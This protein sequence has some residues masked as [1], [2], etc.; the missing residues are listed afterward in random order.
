MHQYHFSLEHKSDAGFTPH[1]F[2]ILKTKVLG[3]YNNLRDFAKES[4]SR[5]QISGAGFTLLEALVVVAI[6][7]IISTFAI[8]SLDRSR[9]KARDAQ[10]VSDISAI[11]NAVELYIED[12]GSVPR[13]G[14]WADFT[15]MVAGYIKNGI[16]S[17][18]TSDDIPYG[19]CYDNDDENKYLVAAL[20]EITA[21]VEGDLDGIQP[22]YTCNECVFTPGGG[23]GNSPSCQ[24]NSGG[25][26]R[27]Q[28]GPVFCLGVANEYLDLPE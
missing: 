22:G 7:V 17:D 11:Q 12:N 28:S 10:R 9:T 14:S 4:F 20:L 25:F 5:I 27:N 3:H 19:Y 21:D 23:C 13:P 24:D 15:A 1:H 18:I 26:L 8:V 2:C 6:I 16:P